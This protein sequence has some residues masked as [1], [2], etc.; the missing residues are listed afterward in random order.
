MDV[1][2][3]LLNGVLEDEVEVEQP[4]RYTKSRK[5]YRVFRLKNAL[6]GLK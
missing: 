2:S 6:Y 5:Y 1:K 4:L 3:V